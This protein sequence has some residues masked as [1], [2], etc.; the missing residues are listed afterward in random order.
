MRTLVFCALAALCVAGKV[1]A[2]TPD[3]TSFFNLTYG[4]L[5]QQRVWPTLL[6][7]A[8]DARPFLDNPQSW[9]PAEAEPKAFRK[10]VE[11][12][13]DYY[14]L[15]AYSYPITLYRGTDMFFVLRKLLTVLHRDVGHFNDQATR[16]PINETKIEK[17]RTAIKYDIGNY[18]AYL[19]DTAWRTY[20]SHPSI[21]QLFHRDRRQMSIY[22][23]RQTTT[24][25]PTTTLSGVQNMAALIK[26][27][28]ETIHDSWVT[29]AEWDS[30]T[31]LRRFEDVHDVRKEFRAYNYTQMF[32]PEVWSNGTN[33]TDFAN[34]TT[35]FYKY[36]SKVKS[37][38]ELY[39]EYMHAG[40]DTLIMEE[41][42]KVV[43][44]WD[45]LQGWQKSLNQSDRFGPQV[46]NMMSNL[47]TVPNYASPGLA[48]WEIALIVIGSLLLAG[49]AAAGAV[50]SYR[51]H[52][53]R[54]S[55]YEFLQD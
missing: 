42:E 35:F 1:H 37:H 48:S 12:G 15:F 20:L 36:Y 16:K 28:L 14:D 53:T 13:R 2:D 52:F 11:Q 49:L 40:N 7:I 8:T 22:F 19:N 39:V 25:L 6:K 55:G 43:K 4:Q 3:R 54:R 5:A 24:D 51:R 29:I 23:W 46:E 33:T 18:T 45:A 34:T 50:Y 27:Y 9:K 17:L 21:T 26:T 47:I 38:L 41:Q 44:A 30:A 10:T 32:F 31:V